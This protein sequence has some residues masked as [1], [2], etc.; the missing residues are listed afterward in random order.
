MKKVKPLLNAG[1]W[2]GSGEGRTVSDQKDSG[3][4]QTVGSLAQ[5]GGSKKS[6]RR[7]RQVPVTEKEGMGETWC[8]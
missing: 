4:G 7:E 2:G 5:N 8:L 6:P 3:Q 1:L